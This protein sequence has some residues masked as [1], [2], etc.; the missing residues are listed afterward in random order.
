M[1]AG[2]LTKNNHRI[3]IPT[4]IPK[5]TDSI[6]SENVGDREFMTTKGDWVNAQF[7]V[8]K[9]S[10]EGNEIF[11]IGKEYGKRVGKQIINASFRRDKKNIIE[12]DRRIEDVT[13]SFVEGIISSLPR[14]CLLYTS[15]TLLIRS[16]SCLKL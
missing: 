9:L 15:R 10:G 2:T 1:S 5:G 6:F 3:S 16:R 11:L 14:G 8:I 12:I 7:N 4:F 13:F